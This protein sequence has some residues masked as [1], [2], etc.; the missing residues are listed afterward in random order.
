MSVAEMVLSREQFK[1]LALKWFYSNLDLTGFGMPFDAGYGR[2]CGRPWRTPEY[3]RGLSQRLVY[4][5]L[6]STLATTVDF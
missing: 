2:W 6:S 4:L 3:W 5:M 1:S